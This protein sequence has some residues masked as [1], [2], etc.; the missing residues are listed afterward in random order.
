MSRNHRGRPHT[1][2]PPGYVTVP[3]AAE[4]LGVSAQTVRNR[5]NIRGRANRRATFRT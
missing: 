3:E 5:I 2:A 4:I 1:Q